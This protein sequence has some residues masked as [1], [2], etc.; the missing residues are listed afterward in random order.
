MKDDNMTNQ[1]TK[2]QIDEILSKAYKIHEVIP[3]MRTDLHIIKLTWQKAQDEIFLQYKKDEEKYLEFRNQSSNGKITK[4]FDVISK[5]SNCILGVIKWDAG[6]RHYCFF[7]TI[8]FS[9]KHSDRCLINIG[10]YVKRLNDE[11]KEE[12]RNRKDTQELQGGKTR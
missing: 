6:W 1:P 11:H 7:P 8:L 5:C 10:L 12:L 2:E 3:L 4:D 9:T